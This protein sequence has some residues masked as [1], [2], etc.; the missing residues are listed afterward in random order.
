MTRHLMEAELLPVNVS[1]RSNAPMGLRYFEPCGLP[2]IGRYRSFF[3]K[4]KLHTTEFYHA[5]F[6]FNFLI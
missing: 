5:F 1:R 3:S 2:P 6:V 4:T